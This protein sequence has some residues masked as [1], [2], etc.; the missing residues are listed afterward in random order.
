MKIKTY[1]IELGHEAAVT[2]FSFNLWE[3]NADH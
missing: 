1:V 3:Q 2:A